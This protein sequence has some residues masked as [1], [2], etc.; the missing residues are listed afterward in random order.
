MN[1]Q[2]FVDMANCCICCEFKT[3]KMGCVTTCENLVISYTSPVQQ[4]YTLVMQFGGQITEITSTI[5]AGLPLQF[6]ISDLNESYTFTAYVRNDITG[7]KIVFLDNIGGVFNRYD[8]FLFK[9]K[10]GLTVN[11]PSTTLTLAP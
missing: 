3:L 8:C 7:D 2:T 6:D 1:F 11:Q 4:N 10:V 5:D 9:T